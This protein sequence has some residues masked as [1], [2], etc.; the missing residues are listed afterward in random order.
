MSKKQELFT[1]KEL[2][3]CVLEQ[4]PKTRNSDMLLYFV[5][6]DRVNATALELPFGSVITNLDKYNLPPFETVRRTRQFIQRKFPELDACEDVQ[7]VRGE[8][9][10]VFKDF[11]RGAV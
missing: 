2:V 8:N 10:A 7:A 6:C 11:A 4:V 5:I 1:T 3:K 9:E